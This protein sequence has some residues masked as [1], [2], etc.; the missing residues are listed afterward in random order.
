VRNCG[1]I[2]P[3]INHPLRWSSRFTVIGLLWLTL[4]F[5]ETIRVFADSPALET[6]KD[7]GVHVTAWHRWATWTEELP[8]DANGEAN[9][10]TKSIVREITTAFDRND[11]AAA[12]RALSKVL[13]CHPTGNRERA[14]HLQA[15][16]TLSTL[17]GPEAITALEHA[18][19]NKE[20]VIAE[21]GIS[22]LTRQPPDIA[23][24]SLTSV[25][26][27][28][29]FEHADA[30]LISLSR[31][32]VRGRSLAV[33]SRFLVDD[34]RE[35]RNSAAKALGSAGVAASTFTPQLFQAVEREG[36]EGRGELLR[37]LA[38]VAPEKPATKSVLRRHLRS[39]VDWIRDAA[40]W[41]VGQLRLEKPELEAVIADIAINDSEE[42]V[43][44]NAIY[45]LG[46]FSSPSPTTVGLLTQMLSN[47]D[48]SFVS[49]SMSSLG[50][51]GVA[52]QCALPRLSEFLQRKN[53]DY[54]K[55]LAAEA[56]GQIGR[57]SASAEIALVQCLSDDEPR[58]R[59]AAAT[60]LGRIGDVRKESLLAIRRLKVDRAADVAVAA[61]LAAWRI[62][63]D[64]SAALPTIVRVMD[65][66]SDN[67][68]LSNS[69]NAL[70]SIGGAARTACPRATRCLSSKSASVRISALEFLAAAQDRAFIPEVKSC[71]DDSVPEVREA[72]AKSLSSLDVTGPKH[73]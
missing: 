67:E 26:E 5:G 65:G 68:L 18:V 42:T 61:A 29:S 12:A 54:I 46:G 56:I 21:A 73:N 35:V 16:F 9:R 20:L 32:H 72:A 33:I 25:L 53:R 1:T 17:D 43:R 13:D 8:S 24:K 51:M 30:V 28:E 58:V 50:R 6:G 45:A 37:A 63:H 27:S 36:E 49:A 60:A 3:S 39:K 44:L 55:E 11:R 41:G 10:A 64:T 38:R 69:L 66:S 71:L 47:K 34:R 4:S 70:T 23:I 22:G 7:I 52:A 31:M 2:G 62:D 15:V 14:M 48:D 40:V 59:R 19:H 57:P